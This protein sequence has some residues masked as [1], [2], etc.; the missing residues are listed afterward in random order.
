MNNNDK[1]TAKPIDNNDTPPVAIYYR[2]ALAAANPELGWDEI[3]DCPMHFFTRL[4]WM[5]EQAHPEL[6]DQEHRAVECRMKWYKHISDFRRSPKML[7]VQDQLGDYGVAGVYRLYEVFAQRFGV[8]DDFTGSIFLAPPYSESWLAE[9]IL[10]YDRNERNED[11]DGKYLS[12]TAKLLHF[13]AVCEQ[14]G[15]IDLTREEDGIVRIKDGVS[16]PTG[17]KRVWTTI[18]IPGFAALKDVWTGTKKASKSKA[19][20]TPE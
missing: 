8:D 17:E 9:E 20:S 2:R 10:S 5:R 19:L 16:T 6:A 14:A 18:T 13:L 4:M 1:P 12:P 11:G 7:Y 3:P 15:L